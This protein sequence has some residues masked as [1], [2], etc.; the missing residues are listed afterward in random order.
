MIAIVA[1][2]FSG[3]TE[4]AGI[5]VSHGLSAEV[6]DVHGISG[7]SDVIAINTHS[8]SLPSDEAR[9]LLTKVAKDLRELKPTHVFKKTDSV[10]RGNTATEISVLA[11]ALTYEN[12]LF[13]PAN[14]SRG[15]CIRDGHYLIN[16]VPLDETFF[17][18]DPEHPVHTSE[19]RALLNHP[20]C[21]QPRSVLEPTTSGLWVPDIPDQATLEAWSKKVPSHTMPAG[22]SDFFTALLGEWGYKKH[23][24]DINAECSPG[25]RLFICGSK[26]GLELWNSGSEPALAQIAL[27]EDALVIDGINE[28]GAAMTPGKDVL[29]HLAAT[30]WSPLLAE[31]ALAD[32]A[33]R[34]I[35]LT[36]PKSIFM[37]GGATAMAMARLNGWHRFQI[38]APGRDGIAQFQPAG[39]SLNLYAKPG[40]YPW[41]ESLLSKSASS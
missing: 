3:A 18:K 17:A 22:A 21:I 12:A 5:A 13:I 40:S 19:V 1:D 31:A 14:P 6:V 4:L 39:S 26:A 32:M 15:R 41:P 27:S 35:R 28:A 34:I 20:E 16:D 8:R 11:K 9:E 33:S 24:P 30:T 10:L 23:T 7:A 37:E 38:T 2:D 29:L 25:P 36:N